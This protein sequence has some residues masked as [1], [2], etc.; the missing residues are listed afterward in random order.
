[1]QSENTV[2]VVLKNKF[3]I[4]C[5]L[6]V[7]KDTATD[8]GMLFILYIFMTNNMHVVLAHLFYLK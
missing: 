5:D 4:L 7:E 1:V 3:E 6:T 8:K 2:S